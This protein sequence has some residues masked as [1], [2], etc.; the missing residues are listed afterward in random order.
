MVDAKCF[1]FI[2]PLF[3]SVFNKERRVKVITDIE[4]DIG[5]FQLKD[6]LSE[7]FKDFKLEQSSRDEIQSKIENGIS[8]IVDL[9]DGRVYRTDDT[10]HKIREKVIR[11]PM[12]GR[13]LSDWDKRSKDLEAAFKDKFITP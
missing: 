3:Q 12:E 8:V 5:I 10:T 13:R 11:D 1:V 9:G 2:E 7:L 6:W 4:G